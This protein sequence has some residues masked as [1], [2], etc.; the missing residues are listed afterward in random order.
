MTVQ[1]NVNSMTRKLEYL[2]PLSS[3]TLFNA[4]CELRQAEG[5]EHDASESFAPELLDD[6][7]SHDAIHVLFAC[8]TN[9]SGEVVAHI[10]TLFGTDTSIQDMHRVNVHEDHR[11]VLREIGHFRLLRMWIS[12]M[13]LVFRALYGVMRMRQRFPASRFAEFLDHRLVDIRSE[14]RIVLQPLPSNGHSTQ[15]AALRHRIR[16]RSDAENPA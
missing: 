13:P 15:G 2:N 4:I 14:Y 5:I 11:S 12:S 8:P 3:Q 9:L 16:Q 1:E 6:I 10:W 7:D